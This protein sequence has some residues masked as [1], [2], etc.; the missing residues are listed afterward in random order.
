MGTR[1]QLQALLEELL[2]SEEVHFQAPSSDKMIYPAIVYNFSDEDVVHADNRPYK[3]VRRYQITL[4]HR[5][6]DNTIADKISDLPKCRFD[7]FFT[8]ANLNHYM[9]DLYF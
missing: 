7:R 9:Y 3:K 1:L 2:G 4:M 5:D 6:P 8:K